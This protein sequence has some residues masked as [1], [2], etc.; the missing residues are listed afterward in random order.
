M[1]VNWI[2]HY[3]SWL[4]DRFFPPPLYFS[5]RR[6]VASILNIG[7]T[8]QLVRYK[9]YIHKK[10][11]I[12]FQPINIAPSSKRKVDWIYCRRW[13]DILLLQRWYVIWRTLLSKIVRNL[14]ITVGPMKNLYW[15]VKNKTINDFLTHLTQLIKL[16]KYSSKPCIFCCD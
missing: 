3:F 15:M 1:T 5:V 6:F 10:N 14:R 2:P 12:Y 7:S 16:L 9:N 8:H 13:S 11:T 4:F